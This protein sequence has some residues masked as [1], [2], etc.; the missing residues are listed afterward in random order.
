M[1]RR[2]AGHLILACSLLAACDLKEVMVPVGEVMIAVHG[3][4]R[5]DAPPRLMGRQYVIVEQT[6]T[7]E[8]KTGIRVLDDSDTIISGDPVTVPFGGLPVFPV[9]DVVVTVA[10]IDLPSDPCGS[11]VTF[12]SDIGRLDPPLE[13]GPMISPGPGVYWSPPGCPTMRPGDR[14]ALRVETPDGQ[15]VTGVTRIPGMNGASF[16]VGSASG[17]FG[18]AD[19]TTFNRDRDT[20]RV[21]VDATAGRLLQLEVRR[22][23]DVTDFGTKIFADTTALTVPGDVINTFVIG[24]ADDVFRAGREY[25]VTVAVT[26]SN[27]FDFARSRNNA[28]TGRGFINHLEGGIGVF[29]S[30]VALTTTLRAVGQMDEDREGVYRM[31]GTLRDTVDVDITLELYLHRPVDSTEFSAFVEGKWLYGDINTSVDGSFDGTNFTAVIVD[32]VAVVREDTLRAEW[33][34]DAPFSVSVIVACAGE[35]KPS[36]ACGAVARRIGTLTATRQ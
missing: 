28:F 33:R 5:P 10:N 36:G 23:G 31:E 18:T 6:L 17:V 22:S 27:Y 19:V 30:L 9:S 29:G 20:L 24:D 4:M 25:F 15:V 1:V 26:D 34:P 3:V 21:Q 11:V 16:S 13:P 12:V 7:G 2:R 32:T 14:L 8:D 35:E